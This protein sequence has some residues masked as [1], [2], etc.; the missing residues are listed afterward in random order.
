[1][2]ARNGL[3]EMG[4]GVVAKVR[5]D[6]ANTQTP[7]TCFQVLRML[8]GRFMKSIDLKASHKM[9][10]FDGSQIIK[11][12]TIYSLT[13]DGFRF[14]TENTAKHLKTQK[15]DITTLSRQR[16]PCLSAMALRKPWERGYN[17]LWWGWTE[18]RRF[19]SNWSATMLTNFFMRSS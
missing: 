12:S 9:W 17:M 8:I 16:L 19:F 3:H 13:L 1:M 5:A 18:G 10:S 14:Q 7:S 11:L 6:V 15:C 4:G 2:H